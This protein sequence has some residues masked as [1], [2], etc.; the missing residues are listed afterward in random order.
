MIRPPSIART[1]SL[2]AVRGAR[3]TTVPA[4]PFPPAE[5]SIVAFCSNAIGGVVNAIS[6]HDVHQHASPGVRGFVTGTGGS[7]NGLGGS[8]A[9]FV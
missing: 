6:R 8:S 7:N 3:K 4:S 2:P 1:P 9:G 5:T